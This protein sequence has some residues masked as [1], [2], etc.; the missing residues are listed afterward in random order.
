VEN[1]EIVLDRPRR[2]VEWVDAFVVRFTNDTV[3]IFG[4]VDRK[5]AFIPKPLSRRNIDVQQVCMTR[6][7]AFHSLPHSQ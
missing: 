6:K 4:K 5:D 7:I 1:T 2:I 3:P